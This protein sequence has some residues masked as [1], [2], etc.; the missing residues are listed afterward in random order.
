MIVVVVE[1]ARLI[2]PDR[3]MNAETLFPFTAD[4][5]TVYSPQSPPISKFSYCVINLG[6]AEVTDSPYVEAIILVIVAGKN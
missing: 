5:A 3:L 6:V 2:V 1:R 4:I